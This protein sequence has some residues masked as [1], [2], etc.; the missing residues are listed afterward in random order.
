MMKTFVPA[1]FVLCALFTILG[2]KKDNNDNNT[3]D[4]PVKNTDPGTFQV[5]INNDTVWNS[6]KHSATWYTKWNQLYINA[7]SDIGPG[8]F[9]AGFVF[10]PSN[11]I[12]RYPLS[13]NGENI[14][15]VQFNNVYYFSDMDTADAGGYFDLTKFDTVKKT[16]SGYLE[17]AGYRVVK[18]WDRSFTK[19]KI[20]DIPL[21]LLD[22]VKYSGNTASYTF[23]EKSTSTIRTN[24]VF[25]SS[26][27]WCGYDQ[28]KFYTLGVTMYSII[29]DKSIHIS[30]PLKDGKGTYGLYPSTIQYMGCGDSYITSRY[31]HRSSIYYGPV[32]QSGTI[33]ILNI[34][35]TLRK[36]N[37]TFNINCRDTVTGATYTITNGQVDIKTWKNYGEQ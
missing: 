25:A 19:V 28:N 6:T 20:D 18:P 21:I 10:D 12:K 7:S 3:P 27:G 15:N 32:V 23:Q 8:S 31:T 30:I 11:P 22:T 13:K 5:T 16:I 2:C 35:T 14:A 24:N 26:D 37:A 29:F 36:L 33:N 9:Y 1:L 34:D 4:T 17:F